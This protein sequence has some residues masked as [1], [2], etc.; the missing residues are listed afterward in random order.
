MMYF[1]HSILSNMFLP[2]DGQISGRNVLMR[3]LWIKYI[4]N[5]KLYLFVINIFLDKSG[6]MQPGLA[7]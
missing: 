7:L 1:I 3:I 6:F 4:I 5:I 2:V